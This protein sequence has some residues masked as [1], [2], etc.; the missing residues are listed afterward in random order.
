MAVACAGD[1]DPV[2][3]WRYIDAPLQTVDSGLGDGLR[4]AL[5]SSQ[6]PGV[7]QI[8]I[9]LVNNIS[10]LN[11]K[12]ILVIEDYHVIENAEVHA[13]INFLLD[14][15]PLR[16]TSSLRLALI[17]LYVLVCVAGVGRYRKSVQR[18]YVSLPT[19]PRPLSITPC[20]WRWPRMI[21]FLL[22][23]VRKAGSRACSW[24]D[25][26]VFTKLRSRLA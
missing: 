24:R 1:N 12:L 26:K 11:K 25:K 8:I 10:T 9:G 6:P 7:E 22:R 18:I 3:F 21:S 19:K 4:P 23:N 16:C 14:N 13:G 15:I 2:R 20:D 5:L 17:R